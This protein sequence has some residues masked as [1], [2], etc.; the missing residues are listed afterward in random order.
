MTW[1]SF[2]KVRRRAADFTAPLKSISLMLS[3]T[4]DHDIFGAD[5]PMHNSAA[6]H[7]FQGIANRRGNMHGAFREK[8]SPLP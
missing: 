8:A 6:V 3:P 5:V 2:V 1:E 4:P 7:V